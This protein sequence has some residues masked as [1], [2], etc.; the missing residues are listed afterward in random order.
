MVTGLGKPKTGTDEMWI[1][2][3]IVILLF[4]LGSAFMLLRSAKIPRIPDHVKAQPYE[5]DDE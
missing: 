4:V 3:F 2:L 5:D 1:V